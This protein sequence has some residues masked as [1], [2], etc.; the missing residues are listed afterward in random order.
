[1]GATESKGNPF[2]FLDAENI[3]WSTLAALTGPQWDEVFR[4]IDDKELIIL[5][6]IGDSCCY[7]S[8]ML[9]FVLKY[10]TT[11]NP[12]LNWLDY[13]SLNDEVLQGFKFSW[14]KEIDKTKKAGIW[15]WDEPIPILT[16]G[17]NDKFLILMNAK[18]PVSYLHTLSD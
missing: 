2:L 6:I 9:N 10:M 14:A 16:P 4:K 17:Q 8:I 12:T 7:N 1:M 11:V 13:S 18:L 15:I 5:T 3:N